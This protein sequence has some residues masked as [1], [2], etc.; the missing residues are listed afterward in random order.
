MM[1]ALIFL[2]ALGASLTGCKT[3]VPTV[4]YR[5]N[6]ES[7]TVGDLPDDILILD[8][9]FV[10]AEDGE[11]RAVKLPGNPVR[12]F[13]FLVG[14]VMTGKGSIN[15]HVRSEGRGRRYPQFGVG[16]MGIRGVRL[17]VA[18]AKNAIN[19]FLNNQVIASTEFNWKA[20]VWVELG[21]SVHGNLAMGNVH[22][23]GAKPVTV[24]A[25][26]PSPA[27]NGRASVWGTP[28]SGE[29]IWFDDLLLRD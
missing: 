26:L 7:E 17:Q 12:R 20:G 11:N 24:S 28:Y 9:D 25:R 14:P 29:P 1:K 4:V 21:L 5:N 22:I 10:V 18:P 16:L 19:L 15:A 13:G 2:A 27:P 23:D 6:F 8:G 3:V